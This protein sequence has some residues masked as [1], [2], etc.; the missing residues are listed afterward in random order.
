MGQNIASMN[1]KN[2]LILLSPSVC[3]RPPPHFHG[4]SSTVLFA[5]CAYFSDVNLPKGAEIKPNIGFPLVCAYDGLEEHKRK[6]VFGWLDPRPI[7]GAFIAKADVCFRG[8]SIWYLF[9]IN[10]IAWSWLLVLWQR[11]CCCWKCDSLLLG[12]F[13]VM[14]PLGLPLSVSFSSFL[15]S[16]LIMPRS[17]L[18]CIVAFDVGFAVPLPCRWTFVFHLHGGKKCTSFAKRAH[19]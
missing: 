7:A 3:L 14:A 5:Y 2:L 17:W 9:N 13:L 6:G 8:S 12:M 4:S 18:F 19:I 16:F 10:A 15:L 1:R 11:C